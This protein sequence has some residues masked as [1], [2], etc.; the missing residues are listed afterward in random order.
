MSH[1]IEQMAYIGATP[2]HGLG[3]ELTAGADLDVWRKEAG[4]DWEVRASDVYYYAEPTQLRSSATR[5]VLYR[6]DTLEPLSVVSNRYKAVQPAEIL[7][8]YR[9]LV[10]DMGFEIETAGSLKGGLKVWALANTKNAH[11]LRAQDELKGY[12]LLATSYDASFATTAQFTGVRVVCNNTL[13][14][15]LNGE[16]GA[17][18]IG[19][20]EDFNEQEVKAQLGLSKETFDRFTG[21]AEALTRV[22]IDATKSHAFYRDLMQISRD[23]TLV[24][25][26]EMTDK[27]LADAFTKNFTEG[28]YIGS[29]LEAS[30]G[31]A[32][33]LV[34]VVT[35][36]LDHV[37]RQSVVGSRFDSAQ[38]GRG[39]VIKNRAF[40]QALELV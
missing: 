30:R 22:G 7:E 4:L 16:S 1:E 36:Y 28:R 10:S 21:A 14:M 18:K 33:G 15:S 8:F 37:R 35:E 40:K 26:R 9:D 3:N 24:K 17:I 32:W 12:L 23:D 11:L 29:D 20:R 6:S 2:W 34:N 25:P 31:T 19:H 5:K 39:A 13:Q 38:F 27:N